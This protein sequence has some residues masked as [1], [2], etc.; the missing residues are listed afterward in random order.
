MRNNLDSDPF[1]HFP[2]LFRAELGNPNA[3]GM[4]LSFGMHSNNGTFW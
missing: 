3:N 2:H 4:F 1:V